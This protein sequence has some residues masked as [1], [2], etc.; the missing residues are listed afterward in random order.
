MSISQHSSPQ[1]SYS[2]P[3][4]ACVCPA[5][6]ALTWSIRAIWVVL[7]CRQPNTVGQWHTCYI[8]Q[9]RRSDTILRAEK[10]TRKQEKRLG[11]EA[12]MMMQRRKASLDRQGSTLAGRGPGPIHEWYTSRGPTWE[13]G[14]VL[15][16]WRARRR[17]RIVRVVRVLGWL[18]RSCGVWKVRDSSA[19]AEEV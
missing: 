2:C 9:S 15:W 6:S 8:Q 16:V 19:R 5:A 1:H 18:G 4:H 7:I 14:W 11:Y 13:I 10:V 12:L 3:Q 17:I